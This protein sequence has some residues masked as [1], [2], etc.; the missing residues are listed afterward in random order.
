MSEDLFTKALENPAFNAETL[1]LELPEDDVDVSDI[2]SS[3]E[4]EAP[5]PEEEKSSEP[6]EVNG[7]KKT[8][9]EKEEGQEILE[10]DKADSSSDSEN[11]IND[12]NSSSDDDDQD[13]DEDEDTEQ[14]KDNVEIED[15]DDDPSPSGPIRS[16]NELPDEPIPEIPSDYHI[17]ENTSITHIGVIHS[18][19]DNNIIIHANLSGEKRVLKD[20]SI[21]CLEDRTLVGTLCEVFGQLQNPFYR[22][23]L[24]TSENEKIASLKGKVGGKA[25]IVTPDAHWVDTFELRRNK[26]TDASNGFDEELPEEEQEFSDDE[27]EALYKKK[28][29]DEKKRKN[30]DKN[31]ENEDG[32]ERPKPN[33]KRTNQR[34]NYVSDK[35][36]TNY[37]QPTS[38]S[39]MSHVRYKSRTARTNFN[40]NHTRDY[41]RPAVVQ[42]NN[43]FQGY[44]NQVIN[45]Q[46]QTFIP[47]PGFQYNPHVPPNPYNPMAGHPPISMPHPLMQHQPQSQHPYPINP[48][49]YPPRPP[50]PGQNVQFMPPPQFNPAYLPQQQQQQ[51]QHP[52]NMQNGN[53]N[54][55]NQLHQL[56]LQQQ[57]QQQQQN[58]HQHQH[59]HQQQ[60]NSNEQQDNRNMYH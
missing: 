29:K 47:P 31:M 9:E 48:T 57:Q 52:V 11:D 51:Q 44:P 56:L 7:T 27:K 25:F 20:G 58:Q 10:G 5:P 3:S 24:P 6:A 53:M 59:Q 28:K 33:K 15:E 12:S 8:E 50:L 49:Y 54:P 32:C 40:D 36:K 46:Q 4:D 23:T 17:T 16:K 43:Q 14:L 35:Q 34:S 38:L 60:G 21:F 26:G 42:N 39:G 13:E 41:G 1:Q 2:S 18:V 45:Q 30:Q 55:V 19:F 37:N 22:V